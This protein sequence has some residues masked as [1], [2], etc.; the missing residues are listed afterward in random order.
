MSDIEEISDRLPKDLA[1]LHTLA[2]QLIP[3]ELLDKTIQGLISID[4][5]IKKGLRDGQSPVRGAENKCLTEICNKCHQWLCGDC[6]PRC[7]CEEIEEACEEACESVVEDEETKVTGGIEEIGEA[8]ETGGTEVEETE[9]TKET[10]GT[11][12]EETEET[13]EACQVHCG[14]HP[15]LFLS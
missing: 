5:M 15:L 13:Q 8:K 4:N 2:P 11:E 6:L 1:R 10:G 3:P 9:E 14:M 7:T 12:A